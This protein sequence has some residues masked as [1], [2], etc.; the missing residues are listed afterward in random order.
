MSRM[1]FRTS[2]ASSQPV[3]LPEQGRPALAQFLLAVEQIGLDD[4]GGRDMGADVQVE[5]PIS[6]SSRAICPVRAWCSSASRRSASG[7]PRSMVAVS[8]AARLRRA[9]VRSPPSVSRSAVRRSIR[10]RHSTSAASCLADCLQQVR[11]ARLQAVDLLLEGETLLE[12]RDG[13]TLGQRTAGFLELSQQPVEPTRR[14]AV[15]GHR[16]AFEIPGL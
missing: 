1:L 4:R 12:G 6:P 13:F 8:T 5:M 7:P 15:A 11:G 9:R 2:T 14:R 3:A 10:A 16:R